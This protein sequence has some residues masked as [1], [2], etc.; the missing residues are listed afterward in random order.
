[1]SYIN[2]EKI[3][4]TKVMIV[5]LLQEFIDEYKM[6]SASLIDYHYGRA[7][8]VETARTMIIRRLNTLLEQPTADVEEVKHGKW[9]KRGNEK[10]CSVCGFIYYSN[11]DD[12]NGCPNCLSKMDGKDTNVPTK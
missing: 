3:E 11:N 10:K 8:G 2:R 12:W 4:E 6:Y 9:I 5:G 7:E 1:M